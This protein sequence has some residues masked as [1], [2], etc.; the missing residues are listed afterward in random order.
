M[1]TRG[2]G[3]DGEFRLTNEF[4]GRQD[5]LLKEIIQIFQHTIKHG[6][7]FFICDDE[8]IHFI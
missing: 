5:N 6:I 8:D 3:R 1:D 7:Q 2:V 4:V